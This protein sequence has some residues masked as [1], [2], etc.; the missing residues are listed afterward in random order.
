MVAGIPIKK[1]EKN[2]YS[3]ISRD[4]GYFIIILIFFILQTIT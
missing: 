4:M 2:K 3:D 1:L